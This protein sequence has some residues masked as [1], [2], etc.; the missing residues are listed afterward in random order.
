MTRLAG[1][2]FLLAVFLNIP[3]DRFARYRPLASYETKTGI[4]ILPVY[5]ER[6]PVCEI[7]IERRAYHDDRVSVKPTISKD[8]VLSLFDQLVSPVE[9]GDPAW[10]LPEGTEFTEVDGSTRATHVM[11]RNVSLVMYGEEHNDKYVVAI[12]SWKNVD[13][14]GA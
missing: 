11:Y 13:C 3:S 2:L 5:S 6:G 4:Q 12:I 14:K 1:S 8:E 7:S 10:K 9:R